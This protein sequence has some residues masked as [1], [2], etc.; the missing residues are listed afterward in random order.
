MGFLRFLPFCRTMSSKLKPRQCRCCKAFFTPEVHHPKRQSFCSAVDCRKASKAASQRRW[1]RKPANRN[2][3][4]DAQN[5][6]RVRQWRQ[7]HPGYWKRAKPLPKPCQLID[8]KALNPE[9]VSCNAPA[10][11]LVPLQDMALTE[12]PAFIGLIS[13]VTGSTLQDHIAVIG[14]NLLIQGRNILGLEAPENH[15]SHH[16]S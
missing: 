12:H 3:F 7:A 1:L 13:L 9:A 8:G 5:V 6:E 2:Y 14:R 15:S 16:D 4:R 10:R 11:D